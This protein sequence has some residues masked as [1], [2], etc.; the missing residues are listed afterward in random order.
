MW[1]QGTF[2]ELS[3]GRNRCVLGR[4]DV[5]VLWTPVPWKGTTPP[6]GQIEEGVWKPLLP[7][8]LSLSSTP[9][10][11]ARPHLASGVSSPPFQDPPPFLQ[12]WGPHPCQPRSRPQRQAQRLAPPPTWHRGACLW[13]STR[14]SGI[15]Q[16][17]G[18]PYP[19]P[20]DLSANW[21]WL[22]SCHARLRGCRGGMI[23]YPFW[24][25]S[26]WQGLLWHLRGS[27][28]TY[29][30]PHSR[31][32]L[33]KLFLEAKMARKSSGRAGHS[34]W[35]PSLDSGHTEREGPWCQSSVSWWSYL[36]IPP[37]SSLISAVSLNLR[38]SEEKHV[39]LTSQKRGSR[40]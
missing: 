27:G 1:G 13:A 32:R 8:G 31:D 21:S 17:E 38:T 30:S 34:L 7:P 37:L 9:G 39:P 28:E 24:G 4:W 35:D 19:L 22:P 11:P 18:G 6:A 25:V 10:E 29:C 33:W 40:L 16:L 36:V 5:E 14:D 26:G 23:P 20:F 2:T 15:T 3:H 12:K